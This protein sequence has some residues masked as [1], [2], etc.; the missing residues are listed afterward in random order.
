M[1]IK[2]LEI[3]IKESLGREIFSNPQ[4]FANVDTAGLPQKEL[5]KIKTID[6]TKLEK[7]DIL[8]ELILEAGPET[9]IRFQNNFDD[10]DFPSLEVSPK[11]QFQT[12][13]G[14]YGYP[15]NQDNLQSLVIS[16]KPTNADFATEYLFFHVY[17]ISKSKT[18]NIEKK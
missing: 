14:I 10:S 6:K 7:K 11:V 18:V 5:T 4:M 9:Y 8:K 12:P 3:F 15:L 1:R 17:K 16:G 13:H 2:L